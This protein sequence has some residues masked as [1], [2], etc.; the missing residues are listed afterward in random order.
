MKDKFF[1]IR[2]DG[3]SSYFT[4]V[5]SRGQVG[6]FFRLGCA[7]FLMFL[8]A[9]SATAQSFINVMDAGAVGNGSADDTAAIQLAINNIS[10]GGTV[11]FP[12][13][14]YKITSSLTLK[15]NIILKGEGMGNVGDNPVKSQIMAGGSMASMLNAVGSD[16]SEVSILGLNFDGRTDLGYSVTWVLYGDRLSSSTIERVRIGRVSGG[17]V[18]FGSNTSGNYILDSLIN[19]DGRNVLLAGSGHALESCSVTHGLGLKQEGVGGHTIYNCHFER[20]TQAGIKIMTP[21]GIS[22]NTVIRNCYFDLNAYGVYL[23]YTSAYNAA[24]DV[25]GCLFRANSQ[26][27][28]YLSNA[29]QVSMVGCSM[30]SHSMA[31]GEHVRMVNSCD[32]ITIKAGIFKDDTLNLVGSHSVAVGNVGL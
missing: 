28:I 1:S 20:A 18:F 16:V 25:E 31:H 4:C 15:N 22:A 13:G 11:Y 7:V 24:V 8:L 17:G 6:S 14:R 30:L 3:C 10:S 26:S 12:V 5:F 32:Y 27:D 29:M 2:Q 9:T 21:S 19:T 23:S